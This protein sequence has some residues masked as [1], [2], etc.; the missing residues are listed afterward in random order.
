ML[1]ASYL[2]T[3]PTLQGFRSRSADAIL[4]ASDRAARKMGRIGG[5]PAHLIRGLLDSG[6]ETTLGFAP[7]VEEGLVPEDPYDALARRGLPLLVGSVAHEFSDVGR[8]FGPLVKLTAAQRQLR[9]E[10][11][12]AY[13]YL[14]SDLGAA[15]AEPALQVGQLATSRWMRQP[16]LTAGDNNSADTWVYDFRLP[17]TEDG[18][19]LHCAE[20]PFV[21]DCLD[22]PTVS[23]N[24]RPDLPQATANSMHQEWVNFVT[25]AQLPWGTWKETRTARVWDESGFHDREAYR[26]EQA[27]QLLD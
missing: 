6:L 8:Q 16:V 24:L 15:S 20:L 25:D 7:T 12:D 3:A 23:R 17:V 19:T 10:L 5:N 9:Q 22:E 21:F 13:P 14:L 4:V 1:L 26:F 18:L 2:K 27:L 11:G